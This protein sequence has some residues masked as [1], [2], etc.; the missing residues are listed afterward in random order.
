LANKTVIP[1]WYKQPDQ[2]LQD[3]L[4][5]MLHPEKS[6]VLKQLDM[7]IGGDQGGG[8]FRMAMKVNF[9]LP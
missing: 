9:R 2:F 1:F 3:Q 4:K 7:V 6:N 8:K 5:S